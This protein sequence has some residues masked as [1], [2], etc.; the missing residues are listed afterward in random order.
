MHLG[1]ED[2]FEVRHANLERFDRRMAAKRVERRLGHV[3]GDDLPLDGPVPFPDNPNG[4]VANTAGAC[5][6]TGRILG[7]MP[8]PERHI[9]PTHHPRWTR[10]APKEVGDGLAVFRNA[11]EYF[12]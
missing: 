9:D 7:L 11:V 1:D 3:D 12:G 10:K 4:S 2:L 5:D 6:P 8:H